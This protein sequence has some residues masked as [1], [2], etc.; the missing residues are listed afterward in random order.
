MAREPDIDAI[1]LRGTQEGKN[2]SGY[3][4]RNAGAT[5][6]SDDEFSRIPSGNE[7]DGRETAEGGGMTM[8]ERE[9]FPRM[10]TSQFDRSFLSRNGAQRKRIREAVANQGKRSERNK[11][12]YDKRTGAT[13]Q[14]FKP[15]TK[16]AVEN[17]QYDVL[18]NGELGRKWPGPFTFPQQTASI[19]FYSEDGKNAEASLGHDPELRR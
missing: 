3:R 19:I 13:L 7:G 2:L 14:N 15:G 11:E 16:V 8:Q 18:M 12:D 17:K 6:L 9:L 10:P 1:N 4:G 5:E